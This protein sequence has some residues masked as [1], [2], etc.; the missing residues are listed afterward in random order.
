[1]AKKGNSP[2]AVWIILRARQRYG[3]HLEE[4]PRHPLLDEVCSFHE[5]YRVNLFGY[6]DLFALLTHLQHDFDSS[7]DIALMPGKLIRH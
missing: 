2:D 1:M 5:W 3:H 4:R 6:F 7:W